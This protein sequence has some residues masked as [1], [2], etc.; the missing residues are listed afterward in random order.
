VL[1]TLDAEQLDVLRRVG[2]EW[3]RVC[4]APDVWRRALPVD[5]G[6]GDFPDPT[7]ISPTRFGRFVRVQSRQA[8]EV[9]ATSEAEVSSS[10]LVRLGHGL[11]RGLLGPPLRSTAIARERMRK[12]VALPV[13]SADALSSVAYGPEAMLAILV[14]GGTGIG[15]LRSFM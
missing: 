8:Q 7:E 5:P 14:L 4:G 15:E 2:R 13:L 10:S 6:L 9:E 11:R 1:A 12:L 3:G